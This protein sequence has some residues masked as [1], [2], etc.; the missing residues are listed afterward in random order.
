MI[1]LDKLIDII[2]V[3]IYLALVFQN[4]GLANLYLMAWKHMKKTPIIK[5][6]GGIFIALSLYFVVMLFVLLVDLLVTDTWKNFGLDLTTVILLYLL[7]TISEFKQ[8]SLHNN[9]KKGVK[10]EKENR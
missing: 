5:A 4:I 2:R 1:Y 7:S 8:T 9:I 6:L 10:K 3:F